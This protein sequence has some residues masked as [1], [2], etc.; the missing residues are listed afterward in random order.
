M[1]NR[2]LS[3]H[4]FIYRF[5]YTMALSILHRAT[6]LA[7][8]VGLLLLIG[9]VWALASGEARY[10]KFS[11]L[12]ATWPVRL[13][14]ALGLLAFVFHLANGIRHLCW[15]AGWGLEKAQARRSA[16]WVVAAVVLLGA[17]LLYAF[18]WRA[19]P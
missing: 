11:A 5:A 13:F 1:T 10:E 15:D 6:G 4:I 2:P 18:F 7:L 9:W 14:M 3:P 12:L 16:V 8:T 17:A 19:L